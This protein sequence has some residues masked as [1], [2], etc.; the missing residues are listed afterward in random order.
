VKVSCFSEPHDWIVTDNPDSVTEV[1]SAVTDDKIIQI[2]A[3]QSHLCH[4]QNAHH[5]KIS[6]KTLMWPNITSSETTFFRLDNFDGV[7]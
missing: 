6:P 3:D 5:C 7:G 1:V 2:L 4:S